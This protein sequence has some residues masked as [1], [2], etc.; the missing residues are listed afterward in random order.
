MRFRIFNLPARAMNLA[1]HKPNN[2]HNANHHWQ[3]NHRIY[4]RIRFNIRKAEHQ[5]AKTEN[6]QSNGEKVSLRGFIVLTEI[7]QSTIGKKQRDNADNGQREE[8]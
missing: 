2:S 4:K 8:N 6:R 1:E 7:M 3:P 5:A